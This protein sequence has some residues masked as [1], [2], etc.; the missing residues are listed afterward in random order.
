MRAPDK[1]SGLVV[2]TRAAY[3]R[4]CHIHLSQG[5]YYARASHI[6]WRTIYNQWECIQKNLLKAIADGCSWSSDGKRLVR[7]LNSD[8]EKHKTSQH[9]NKFFGL[10]KLHKVTL[11]KNDLHL[12][13]TARIPLRPVVSCTH[14]FRR[15]GFQWLASLLKPIVKECWGVVS[16]TTEAI[17]KMELVVVLPDDRIVAIDIK[18]FYLNLDAPMITHVIKSVRPPHLGTT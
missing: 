18:E 15:F 3:I 8:L 14:D 9:T 6:S 5:S 11:P 17:A 12:F 2:N 4:D 13:D 10:Y 7:F 16:S 1:F